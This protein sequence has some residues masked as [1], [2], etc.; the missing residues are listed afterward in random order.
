MDWK[1]AKTRHTADTPAARV[2]RGTK[3]ILARRKATPALHGGTPTAVP[4][5]GISGLFAVARKAPTGTVLCLYNFTEGWRHLPAAWAW[6]QGIR[7]LYDALSEA[8]V[9]TFDGNIALP[10]YARVWLT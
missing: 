2:F 5:T 9:Q 7:H 10:P 4:E 8:P 1:A 6:S 3:H